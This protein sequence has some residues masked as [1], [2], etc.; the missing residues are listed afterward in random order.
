MERVLLIALG[1]AIGTAARYLASGI[2]V[3]W[4]GT[5]F[6]YGTLIVNLVGAFAIGVIQEI[7]TE[8]LVIPDHARLFLTTGI[9]GGL[10][11]YSTFSY[12]TVRLLEAN[13]WYRASVNVVGTTVA[14]GVITVVGVSVVRGRG[15]AVTEGFSYTSAIS[16]ALRVV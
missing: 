6:P 16:S 15:V 1:G 4:L 5:D 10:T 11:T 8:S 9:M 7:G 3:R 13:A 14:V 12:E 2:A